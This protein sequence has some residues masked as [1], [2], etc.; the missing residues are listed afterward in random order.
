MKICPACNTKIRGVPVGI[1]SA[2]VVCN[3]CR[4]EWQDEQLAAEDAINDKWYK[5]IESNKDA[6]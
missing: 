6:E 1:I 5:R 4:L 3:D 2:H